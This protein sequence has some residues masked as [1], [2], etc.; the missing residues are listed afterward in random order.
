MDGAVTE[1]YGVGNLFLGKNTYIDILESTG[2]DGN[3]IN[4]EHIRCRGIPTSCITYKAS[5]N[6]ITV[7]GICK[8][9]YKGEI[10]EFDLTNNLTKYVCKK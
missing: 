10:I 6:K 2:K 4:S 3:T 1:I 9:L 5:Q 7:L 8:N